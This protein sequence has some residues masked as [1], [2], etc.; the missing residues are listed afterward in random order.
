MADCEHGGL[1]VV[2]RGKSGQSAIEFGRRDCAVNVVLLT[3][4]V[5]RQWE[6]RPDDGVWINWRDEER[7]L[8]GADVVRQVRIRE[9]AA[10]EVEERSTL[11]T[12]IRQSSGSIP[13]KLGMLVT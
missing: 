2:R 9:Q 7:Q 12:S 4:V 3:G 13:T 1:A 8:V 11:S 6:T 10:G 5:D